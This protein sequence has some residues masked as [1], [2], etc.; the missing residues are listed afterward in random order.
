MCVVTLDDSSTRS[1]SDTRSVSSA[2]IYMEL[3]V[4][5]KSTMVAMGYSHENK[6]TDGA[7]ISQCI[8]HYDVEDDF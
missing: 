1:L 5:R 3:N 6:A 4:C 8:S 7:V 2:G